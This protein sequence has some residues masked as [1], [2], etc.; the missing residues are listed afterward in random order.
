MT[1]RAILSVGFT[2]IAL[3]A[4]SVSPAGADLVMRKRVVRHFPEADWSCP[5]VNELELSFVASGPEAVLTFIASEVDFD[6]VKIESVILVER[7]KFMS[8]YT[9]RLDEDCQGGGVAYYDGDSLDVNL[10]GDPSTWS[11]T[12]AELVDS[13][14]LRMGIVPGEAEARASV[15]VR[16]LVPGHEYFITGGSDRGDLDIEV[17]CPP[18]AAFYLVNGRFRVE[19]LWGADA[20]LPGVLLHSQQ[21][22][23]LWFHDRSQLTMI[24]SATDNCG[25]SGNGTFWLMF[26]GTTAQKLRITVQDTVTG[27]Q[28]TYL[29]GAQTRLKTVV[30]KKTFRCRR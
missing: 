20:L 28:K 16:N 30:D 11:L 1:R 13:S 14:L 22:A 26:A 10:I 12:N 29:N 2:L 3:A 25:L 19:V 21:T 27:I 8:R 24:V 23:G 17:D 4:V 18:P 7:E 6:P 15:L 9:A 5:F